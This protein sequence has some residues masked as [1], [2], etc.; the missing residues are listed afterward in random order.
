MSDLAPATPA[1]LAA[2]AP[3]LREADKTELWLSHQNTP[4]QALRH[5]LK[6]SVWAYCLVGPEGPIAAFGLGGAP[7]SVIC[8]PWALAAD[9]G[10]SR[11][12]WGRF[13]RPVITKMRRDVELLENWVHA[14]NI[15][16]IRWLRSCG[17][18]LDAAAP[19]GALGAPFHR[20]W[21]K[22]DLHV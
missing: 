13:S 1:L 22:G 19:Y 15:V 21:M 5:A 20:F 8:S 4:E 12:D 11:A 9:P 17:F 14:G 7:M 18:T 2:L 16:S 6:L 3:R 10:P